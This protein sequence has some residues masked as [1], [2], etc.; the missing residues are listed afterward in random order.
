MI[1]F[2]VDQTIEELREWDQ[3]HAAD[4]LVSIAAYGRPSDP[5]Y[6]A[7]WHTSTRAG[8]EPARFITESQPTNEPEEAKNVATLAEWQYSISPV[9]VTA[10]GDLRS[11]GEL[12]VATTWVY[13]LHDLPG[14]GGSGTVPT[15]G[16]VADTR[17]LLLKELL[18]PPDASGNQS[19]EPDGCS[20]LDVVWYTSIK[21]NGERG[22]PIQRFLAV[23]RGDDKTPY[24]LFEA[25][26]NNLQL[27]I[28]D[29]TFGVMQAPIMKKARGSYMRLH[30]AIPTPRKKSGYRTTMMHMKRDTY[31]AW[32]KDLKEDFACG[33]ITD[34]PLRRSQLNSNFD[35]RYYSQKLV[36]LEVRANGVGNDIRFCVT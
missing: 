15:R 16:L 34:G 18:P 10:T 33:T 24:D 22:K 4:A 11:H 20:S 29:T 13:V 27:R 6:A 7:I 9:L 14:K 23:A 28:A 26:A 19:T 32:P 8:G 1:H 21:P 17:A 36:P 35:E 12:G 30:A 2:L 31:E 5:R 25:S 3:H